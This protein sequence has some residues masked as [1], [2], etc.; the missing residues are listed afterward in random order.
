MEEEEKQAQVPYFVHEGMVARMERMF[1]MTVIALVFAL[2]VCVCSLV[3]NDTMWRKHCDSLESRY[4]KIY[5]GLQYDA[6]IHEQSD[7]STD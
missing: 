4:E 5:E 7:Q 1:K 6:R 2:A 3:I